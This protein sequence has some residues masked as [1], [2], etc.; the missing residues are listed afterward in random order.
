MNMNLINENENL[1]IEDFYNSLLSSGEIK[2][3]SFNKD[4]S[5]KGETYF[6]MEGFNKV[7]INDDFESCSFKNIEE[8]NVKLKNLSNRR[9]NLTDEQIKKFSNL[10]FL[11]KSVDSQN[12]DVSEFVY[13]MF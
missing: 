12:S 11:L 2:I 10:A 4:F 5:E 1:L 6:E 3:N 13:V 8:L 9:V 7:M